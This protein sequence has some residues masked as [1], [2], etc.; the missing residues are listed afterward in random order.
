MSF[1]PG[2]ISV[3]AKRLLPGR[4]TPDG[5]EHMDAVDLAGNKC[6]AVSEWENASRLS[7][8]PL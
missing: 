1:L 4:D 5:P 2:R 7:A 6:D 3:T 8:A